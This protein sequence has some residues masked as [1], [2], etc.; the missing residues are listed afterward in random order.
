MLR[1]FC[2]NQLK[3]TARI[4]YCAVCVAF[5]LAPATATACKYSV[6]D[7]GFVDLSSQPYRLYCFLDSDSHADFAAEFLKTAQSRFADSNVIAEVIDVVANPDHPALK[8]RSATAASDAPELVL[9]APESDLYPLPVAVSATEMGNELSRLVASP[10]RDQ[11]WNS[12]VEA[13]AVVVVIEG[14]SAEE[15]RRAADAGRFA[16]KQ[17]NGIMA[18]M[19]KPVDTPPKLLTVSAEQAAQEPVLLWS[20]GLSAEERK[21]PAVVTLFGRGR[22]LGPVVT[23]SDISGTELFETL[24]LVGKSCECELDR[25]WMQGPMFPHAWDINRQADVTRALG[26]DAENPLIKVE[27]SRIIARGDQNRSAKDAVD[28]IAIDPLLGYGEFDV[29]TVSI[30]ESPLDEAP[31]DEESADSLSTADDAPEKPITTEVP[32][33][34]V[35]SKPNAT[36]TTDE[37]AAEPEETSRLASRDMAVITTALL[38]IVAIG[39]GLFLL[40]RRQGQ[41]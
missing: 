37:T 2:N 5:C 20:W 1:R 18:Q 41:A 22:Q 15:N 24:A 19:D 21:E 12:I 36:T 14:E 7:V 39:G 11:I 25:S 3:R 8:Y 16:I 23:G 29:D 6:R 26:F 31:L 40:Y 32:P 35:A 34:V 17:L 38:C 10:L 30:D 28:A 27:I 9:V 13:Y 4:L 33:A